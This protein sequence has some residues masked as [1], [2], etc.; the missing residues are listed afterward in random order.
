MRGVPISQ[1]TSL[2][3]EPLLR[4]VKAPY[5]I[6]AVD[7]DEDLRMLYADV[8]VPMRYSVDAAA[9]GA[10]A[11][12]ALRCQR[13]DLMITDHDLPNCDGVELVRRA[14]VSGMGLPVVMTTGRL[15]PR[16]LSPNP[17]PEIA[18]I[19]LKPFSA[20]V[21]LDTVRSILG[22]TNGARSSSTPLQPCRQCVT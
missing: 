6:L 4:P 21:L 19:L 7:E 13:Y 17:L 18:A 15:P 9:D 16:E 12:Q 3:V 11:W 8:L 22:A 14:R 20:N 10:S 5:R 2:F 1:D